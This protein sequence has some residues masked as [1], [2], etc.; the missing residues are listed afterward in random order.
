[1]WTG[2]SPDFWRSEGQGDGEEGKKETSLVLLL[3]RAFAISCFPSS[4][5]DFEAGVKAVPR[6]RVKPRKVPK[7]GRTTF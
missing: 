4:G 2:L 5:L 7:E 3:K 6:F 1:M